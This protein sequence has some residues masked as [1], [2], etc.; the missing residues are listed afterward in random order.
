MGNQASLV[1]LITEIFTINTRTTPGPHPQATSGYWVQWRCDCPL[2]AMVC[3]MW[4]HLGLCT[5]TKAQHTKGSTTHCVPQEWVK[6][7]RIDCQWKKLCIFKSSYFKT[8]HR[9][10]HII[11]NGKRNILWMINHYG[12]AQMLIGGMSHIT[13]FSHNMLLIIDKDLSVYSYIKKEQY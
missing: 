2:R 5:G 4:I 12:N 6:N 13:Q 1:P 11:H 9:T 7:D 3:S 8:N 10:R